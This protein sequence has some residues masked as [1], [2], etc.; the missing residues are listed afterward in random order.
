M[1]MVLYLRDGY[2][3][4]IWTQSKLGK[5]IS[6][7]YITNCVSLCRGTWGGNQS[8]LS[9]EIWRYNKISA[10]QYSKSS[11]SIVQQHYHINSHVTNSF[12]IPW[13]PLSGQQEPLSTEQTTEMLILRQMSGTFNNG[14][15]LLFVC[16]FG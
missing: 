12:N 10:H 16:E 5:L 1:K 7:Q 15:W 3:I 4:L 9:V 14:H 6:I 11:V 8:S 2:N 13:D